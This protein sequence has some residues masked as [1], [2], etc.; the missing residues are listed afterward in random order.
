MTVVDPLQAYAAQTVANASASAA[1][2]DQL[3]QNEFMKLMLAQLK[4]QDPMKP[5][6]PSQF[7]GQLA[8]FSTVTGIQNMQEAVTELSSSM[9]SS[10]VLSGSTLVGHD[11][12]A[13]SNTAIIDSGQT[14][15]GAADVP[16]GATNIVVSVRDSSGQ[17]VNRFA[18][19][20][21]EGLTDFTWDGTDSNGSA[22]PAGQY[23]FEVLAP[24]GGSSASLDPLL[25]SRVSSVTIDPSG[26]LTLNTPAGTVAIGDV[27]RVL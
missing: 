9:R 4:N 26:G 25:Q 11:I 21:Q 27:R 6:D 13:P 19:P 14:V 1:K 5:L 16:A 17:L 18:V 8:Q 10:Q 3:G 2:S 23:T 22:V 20:A 7:L 24:S 15:H 12:L